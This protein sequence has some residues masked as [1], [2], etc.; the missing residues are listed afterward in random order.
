MKKLIAFL[1][2]LPF[3]LLSARTAPACSC[4]SLMPD[5]AFDRAQAV[6][7]GKVIKARKKEWTVAVDRV[8][9]GGPEEIIKLQDAHAGSS[10]ASSYKSGE[11][12]LFLI[13]VKESDGKV[14]YSPQVCTWTTRLKANRL[15]LGE[16]GSFWV[17]DLVLQGRGEGNLPIKKKAVKR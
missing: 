2:V 9:K 11:S 14:V 5:Q 12:Y 15:D 6:F 7:T 13:N 8:W 1:G 16:R 3:L 17:E 4:S 10:C